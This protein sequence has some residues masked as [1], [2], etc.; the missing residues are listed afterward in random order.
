[1]GLV[2]LGDLCPLKT[3]VCGTLRPEDSGVDMETVNKEGCVLEP[4]EI[5]LRRVKPPLEQDGS[6]EEGWLGDP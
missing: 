6:R 5:F 2:F 1:M 4:A 3:V